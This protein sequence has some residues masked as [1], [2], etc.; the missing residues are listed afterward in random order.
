MASFPVPCLSLLMGVYI[1]G[2]Q[3][4]RGIDTVHTDSTRCRVLIHILKCVQALGSLVALL[5]CHCFIRVSVVH[6]EK[7]N[8]ICSSQSK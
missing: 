2:I 3:E 6:F 7:K 1:T 5:T 8:H 4:S